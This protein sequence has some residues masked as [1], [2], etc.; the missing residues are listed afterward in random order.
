MEEMDYGMS[1]SEYGFDFG[2][3]FPKFDFKKG[4]SQGDPLAP[5]LFIITMEGLHVSMEATC[6]Q[7]HFSGISLPNNGPNLL[8]LIY[9]NDVIFMGEWSEM[10]FINTVGS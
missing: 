5:F 10:N 7:H 4:V 8:H 6:D 9:A 3:R 1:Q 2:Q